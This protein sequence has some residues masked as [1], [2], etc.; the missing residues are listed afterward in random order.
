MAK[1]AGPQFDHHAEYDSFVQTVFRDI[2]DF[3]RM[4]EDPYW[5]EV[6]APDH[7][8][9][10]HHTVFVCK[11]ILRGAGVTNRDSTKHDCGVG[12]RPCP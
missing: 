8:I 7:E 6:V 2:E 12:R 11:P 1:I 3:V 9:C 4:K 10:G 5:K